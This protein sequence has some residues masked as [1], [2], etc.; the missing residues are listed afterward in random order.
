RADHGVEVAHHARVRQGRD[1]VEDDLADLSAAHADDVLAVQ[2]PL[3]RAAGVGAGA[4][5]VDDLGGHRRKT[6]LRGE[7]VEVGERL[8]QVAIRDD[9]DSHARR[10]RQAG[11]AIDRREPGRV[12][13]DDRAT[14]TA[15]LAFHDMP[16]P[17]RDVH[18]L[19]AEHAA[20]AVQRSGNRRVGRV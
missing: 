3:G 18:R 13:A 5:G 6:I 11:T 1:V 17:V 20:Y 8:G 9:A 4:T 10:G 12:V 16:D 2:I 19:Q 14:T 7:G 15:W